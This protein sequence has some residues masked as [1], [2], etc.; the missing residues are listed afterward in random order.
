MAAIIGA[1]SKHGLRIDAHSRNQCDKSKLAL[2]KPS[3]H[4]NS[5]LKW[6]YIS[7]KMERFRYKSGVVYMSVIY[8]LRHLKGELTW[9][10]DK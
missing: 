8:I 5:C 10:T 3:I 7:N 4:F 9:A 2:Y 6:L 1:I